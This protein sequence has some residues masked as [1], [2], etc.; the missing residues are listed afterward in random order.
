M[1]DSNFRLA[2]FEDKRQPIAVAQNW[3]GF[4]ILPKMVMDFGERDYD[5]DVRG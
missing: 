5:C 4:L 2:V 1:V 3:K